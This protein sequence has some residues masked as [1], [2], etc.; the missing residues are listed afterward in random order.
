RSIARRT[1]LVR[2]SVMAERYS[3]SEPHGNV[4]CMSALLRA[5]LL[6]KYISHR[7]FRY[8][9]VNSVALWAASLMDRAATR[10]EGAP[11]HSHSLGRPLGAALFSF[12]DGAGRPAL[13]RSYDRALDRPP[14]GASSS[15]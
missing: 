15:R 4:P 13:H 9:M 12:P 3:A 2:S 1:M 7:N 5:C 11:F 6:P 14:Q 10:M 8:V